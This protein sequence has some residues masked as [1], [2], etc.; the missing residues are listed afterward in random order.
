MTRTLA[1]MSV[2]VR[3][4][5][6]RARSG[7]SRMLTSPRE[8]Q[9]SALIPEA[10]DTIDCRQAA[11]NRSVPSRTERVY[12]IRLTGLPL[13]GWREEAVNLA[14]VEVLVDPRDHAGAG[15]GDEAH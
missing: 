7:S 12:R 5:V 14:P 13:V 1:R 2:V 8:T 4:A 3:T 11:A 10:R 9:A 15:V 6:A